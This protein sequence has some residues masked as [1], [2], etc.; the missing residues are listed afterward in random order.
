[1]RT[2]NEANRASPWPACAD[3]HIDE[4]HAEAK[5]T[6]EG[7]AQTTLV[8]GGPSGS[9]MTPEQVQRCTASQ[10]MMLKTQWHVWHCP[11]NGCQHTLRF[12]VDQVESIPFFIIR[13]LLRE[14][15]LEPEAII[16]MEP[17]LANEVCEYCRSMGRGT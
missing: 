2:Q 4:P 16:A 6:G 12:K 3:C 5:V 14:H 13:H 9:E 11:H 15:R 8:A 1:M 10:V 17:A 7:Y